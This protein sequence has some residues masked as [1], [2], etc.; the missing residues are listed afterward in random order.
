MALLR[1]RISDSAP[2][3]ADKPRC[4]VVK[5]N[6]FEDFIRWILGLKLEH[7]PEV[8]PPSSKQISAERSVKGKIVE[9]LRGQVV[10]RSFDLV[11]VRSP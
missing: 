1:T 10:I 8:N 3:R 2:H 5:I 4:G 9:S 11:V 7:N 6:G